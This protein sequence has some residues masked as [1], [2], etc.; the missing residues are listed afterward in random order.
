M[1][2]LEEGKVQFDET[3]IR[4]E[5]GL[6]SLNILKKNTN[7]KK[8]VTTEELVELIRGAYCINVDPKTISSRLSS[9]AAIE[10]R[11]KRRIITTKTEITKYTDWKYVHPFS[12][13]ELRYLIDSIRS[14]K[15]LLVNDKEDLCNRIKE[16][17]GTDMLDDI[18]FDDEKDEVEFEINQK[19][20][21]NIELINKAI[22]LGRKIKFSLQIYD[23]DK[24]FKLVEDDKGNV[25]TYIVFPEDLAIKDG[26]Y[27]MIATFGGEKRCPF[28]VDKIDEVKIQGAVYNKSLRKYKS[29]FMDEYT[30][31][32]VHMF[33]GDV[34][35]IKIQIK[36]NMVDTIITEFVRDVEFEKVMDDEV[37]VNIKTNK[38]AFDMWLNGYTG[39]VEVLEK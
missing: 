24:S 39:R 20:M 7:S 12:D 34:E 1:D 32:R 2:I 17:S 6:A 9:V 15:S 16:L 14:N 5:V 10:P 31:S 36:K 25:K 30:E 22:K 27:Y 35:K 13:G 23:I 8:T 18:V 3:D 29:K 11:I 33:S 19:Y 37:I 4:R 38:K 21:L 26:K 28:R